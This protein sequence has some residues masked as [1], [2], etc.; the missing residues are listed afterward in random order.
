[1]PRIFTPFTTKR[2]THEN[3]IVKIRDQYYDAL[4]F[5]DNKGGLYYNGLHDHFDN[6]NGGC[7]TFVV[8]NL[9]AS[10]VKDFWN[11]S[12]TVLYQ[13]NEGKYYGWGDLSRNIFTF[14]MNYNHVNTKYS[15]MRFPFNKDIKQI[16]ATSEGYGFLL[17]DGTF[18]MTGPDTMIENAIT[19]IRCI[20]TD[21]RQLICTNG[22]D[23]VY[24]K[25]E[26]FTNPDHVGRLYVSN[27]KV[28]SN[29]FYSEVR[30]DPYISLK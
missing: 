24:V 11:T 10:N 15:L 29:Y 20:D 14:A 7:E 9:I 6:D 12:T 13:T 3:Q 19:I 27:G 28:V 26:D 22:K 2:Y 18:Y 17:E 5:L 23:I 25:N 16:M 1:M 4:I 21:V 30:G 8:T